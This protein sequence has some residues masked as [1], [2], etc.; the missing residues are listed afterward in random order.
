MS[1]LLPRF[2][3][4]RLPFSFAEMERVQTAIHRLGRAHPGQLAQTQGGQRA[5]GLQPAQHVRGNR[6]CTRWSGFVRHGSELENLIV[7]QHAWLVI[8]GTLLDFA[9]DQLDLARFQV[10]YVDFRVTR[11]FE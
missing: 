1:V 10:R 8:A 2:P 9:H 7:L 11:Q 3:V 6:R 5:N 4:A